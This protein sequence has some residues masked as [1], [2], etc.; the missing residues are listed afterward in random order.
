MLM[1]LLPNAQF[2]KDELLRIREVYESVDTMVKQY[3]P[4]W[5]NLSWD[6][7]LV[8]MKALLA[9]SLGYFVLY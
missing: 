2:I 6:E 1:T 5:S 4:K 9:I 3:T 8:R 7:W